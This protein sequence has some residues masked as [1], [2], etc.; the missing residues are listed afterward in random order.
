LKN[1]SYNFLGQLTHPQDNQ[2]VRYII[3][4]KDYLTGWVEAETIRDYNAE[5]VAQFL[6]K[7][8]VTRFG[9]PIV[10]MIDQGTHFLNRKI[11]ALIEEF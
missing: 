6:F 1:G 8:V 4:V 5:T 7:N 11:T 9:F 3:T 2:N 10:L